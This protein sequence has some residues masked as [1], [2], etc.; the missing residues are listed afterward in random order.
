[1]RMCVSLALLVCC[2]WVGATV[3]LGEHT[4]FGHVAR[5][6]E[7]EETQDLIQG[8]QEAAAPAVDRVKKG[9]EAARE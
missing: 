7:A 2:V 8:T 4:F 5:I 9:V 6:W 3:P 1:M